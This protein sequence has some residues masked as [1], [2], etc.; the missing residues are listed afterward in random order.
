VSNS[1]IDRTGYTILDIRAQHGSCNFSL[2]NSKQ[3]CNQQIGVLL[4]NPLP[5]ISEKFSAA[6][7]AFLLEQRQINTRSGD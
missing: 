3:Y 7:Q 6:V 1:V 4:E 5:N 2:V